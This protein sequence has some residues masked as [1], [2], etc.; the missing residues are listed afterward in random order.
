MNLCLSVLVGKKKKKK[1]LQLKEF[2]PSAGGATL[3]SKATRQ[4]RNS[5][6]KLS[7]SPGAQ[8]H[9]DCDALKPQIAFPGAEFS[10]EFGREK[11]A[12]LG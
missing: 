12:A 6:L 1:R 8:L 7:S 3:L 10:E 9:S 5:S 11:C 4:V 2:D